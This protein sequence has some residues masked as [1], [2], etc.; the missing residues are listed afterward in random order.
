MTRYRNSQPGWVMTAGSIIGGALLLMPVFSFRTAS[1]TKPLLLLSAF[2]VFAMLLLFHSLTAIV[3]DTHLKVY[4]GNGIIRRTILLEDIEH[5]IAEKN[6]MVFGWG[7]RL[8]P[9]YVLWNVSGFDSVELT[10][11]NKPRRFRIG[12]DRPRELCDA[13]INAISSKQ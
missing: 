13:I 2:F 4:F 10:L 1:E 11:K 3:T 7:I 9:G 12:T 6:Q 5:C 8:G